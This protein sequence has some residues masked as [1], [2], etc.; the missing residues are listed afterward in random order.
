MSIC[1]SINAEIYEEGDICVPG[2]YFADFIKKL[3]GVE[4][5]LSTKD[6]KMEITYADSRTTIQVLPSDE[7][8]K[9]DTQINQNSFVMKTAEL[10]RVISSTSF[11]SATD[12]SRPILKGCQFIVVGNT[13]TVT[14]LDGFRLATTTA[15]VVRS[16]CDM[17]IICPARMLNE[18]EKMLPP[19]EGET[20]V[21]VQKGM[22]LVSVDN[23][24]ITSRLYSG[25]F[26]KKDNIIPKTFTSV[27]TVDKNSL[28]SSIERASILVRNEKNNL[29]VFTISQGKLEIS[30]NSEIG[31]VKEPVKAEL[32]GK[33]LT[34]AMN[35]KFI[36]DAINALDEDTVVLSFNSQVQPFILENSPK[37]KSLYLI[38][39]VRVVN[40]A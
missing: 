5:M 20:E 26:I 8:P 17:E 15:E 3:E 34:I 19:E 11:C 33:D 27:V 12:D 25:D 18:I 28:K 35:A 32:V 37:K 9:I 24:V 4:L 16:S 6:D 14:A 10:K 2:K 38:L 31:D 13:L 22:I 21:F 36:S 7:F 1:K 23:T 29:I 40:N 30:A 39:P